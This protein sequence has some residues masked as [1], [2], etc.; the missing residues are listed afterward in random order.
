MIKTN[1][2]DKQKLISKKML[3]NRSLKS[4]LG[5]SLL[6]KNSTSNNLFKK[7]CSKQVKFDL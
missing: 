1:K 3:K 5:M 4:T 2:K 7:S 6:S